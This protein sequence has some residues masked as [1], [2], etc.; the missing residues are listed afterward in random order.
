MA[1]YVGRGALALIRS[2]LG[3]SAP[4]PDV[5]RAHRFFIEYYGAH[6]LDKTTLYPGV[7]EALE[8]RWAP[9]ALR[10]QLGSARATSLVIRNK[11]TGRQQQQ[12][13]KAS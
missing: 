3:E 8:L 4:E 9:V 6:M 2:A 13:S 5:Q 7:R 11:C 10:L 1:K 12:P